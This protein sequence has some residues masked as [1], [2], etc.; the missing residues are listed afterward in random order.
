MDSWLAAR[1]HGRLPEPD[2]VGVAAKVVPTLNGV[3]VRALSPLRAPFVLLNVGC[4]LRVVTQTLTDFTP[5]AFPIAGLSGVLETLGLAWWGVHLWAVTAGRYEVQTPVSEFDLGT[6]VLS[7]HRVG[8]VVE[9]RPEL[10]ETFVAFGFHPLARPLLRRTVA[11]HVTIHQACR[12]MGVD[13][14]RLLD[15]LNAGPG[16]HPGRLSLPILS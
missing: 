16:R 2:I 13:E 12:M 4:A 3:D 15:A 9:R 6:L 10:L 8:D 5:L 7:S 1:D 11:R 14:R